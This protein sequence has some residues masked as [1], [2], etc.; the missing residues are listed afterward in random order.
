[1]RKIP[2][3]NPNQWA[4]FDFKGKLR[5]KDLPKKGKTDKNPNSK[6]TIPNIRKIK[7]II[8]IADVF[9]T[10]EYELQ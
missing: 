6:H 2:S 9:L 10:L 3:G 8:C 5:K 7:A 1:M 4:F